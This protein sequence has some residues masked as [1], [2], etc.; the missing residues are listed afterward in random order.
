MYI[1]FIEF[2]YIL[3]SKNGIIFNCEGYHTQWGKTADICINFSAVFIDFFEN[4]IGTLICALE[5]D[6]ITP[7]EES[8]ELGALAYQVDTVMEIMIPD[9]VDYNIMKQVYEALHARIKTLD[10]RKNS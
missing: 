10:E 2:I 6:R 4:E 1:H 9:I 8:I 3:S 7:F 5:E